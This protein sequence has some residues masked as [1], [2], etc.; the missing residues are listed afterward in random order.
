MQPGLE[1]DR[2]FPIHDQPSAKLML[3]KADCLRTAGVIGDLERAA[4]IIQAGRFLED[5]AGARAPRV[6]QAA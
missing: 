2:I 5:N 6:T 3:V 4:V 1:F